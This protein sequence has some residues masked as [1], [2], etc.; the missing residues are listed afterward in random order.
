MSAAGHRFDYSYPVNVIVEA[1]GAFG[2]TIAVEKMR[3]MEGD[4]LFLLS[5]EYVL[6]TRMT[7]SERDI[8]RMFYSD[9]ESTY[10]ELAAEFNI[11]PE[12]MPLVIKRIIRKLCMPETWDILYNGLQGYLEKAVDLA[13]ESGKKEKYEAG[14]NEGYK[15][16]YEDGRRVGHAEGHSS[17]QDVQSFED[18]D[19]EEEDGESDDKCV[20]DDNSF[21]S[22]FPAALYNLLR[23]NGITTIEDVVSSSP[24]KVYKISGM[25]KK[26]FYLLVSALNLS[27]LSY[28]KIRPY[29]EFYRR[30]VGGD[31]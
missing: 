3:E 13:Y 31:I 29:I 5:F 26:K 24:E 28:K 19:I 20:I 9:S 14:Y 4:T 10:K 11:R 23:R 16:G 2:K 18:D 21:F 30:H 27:G 1:A 12:K 22:Q 8:I 6:E 15:K 7:Q 17:Y 25:G